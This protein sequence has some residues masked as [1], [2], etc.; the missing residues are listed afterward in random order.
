[1]ENEIT[2]SL[3]EY[4][5][6]PCRLLDGPS[7]VE[8]YREARTRGEQEGFVPILVDAADDILLET[9]EM[10]LDG[11]GQTAEDFRRELLAAP[12]EEGGAYFS[13]LLEDKRAE[14]AA[15][16]FPWPGDVQG[17]LSGG[18]AMDAFYGTTGPLLLAEIPV[19]H[20]W[21]VF[22]YLPFGGW[23]EC[24]DTAGLMAAAKYWYEQYGAVPV[25]LSHDVLQWEVPAPVGRKRA[26]SLAMEQYAWC[27]D[28]VDQGCGTVGALADG[29]SRSTV[30]FFWW[31]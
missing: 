19:E 1:M 5:G 21:E 13:A 31:D 16:G 9:L 11:S 6:C 30:W 23:N 18:E 3:V 7:A 8:A 15:N 2:K 17:E 26:V 12:I 4:L 28:L 14:A 24:P 20:P 22:A 25:T 27:P 10:A 29:L